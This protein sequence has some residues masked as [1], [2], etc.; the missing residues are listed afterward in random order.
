MNGTR[1]IYIKK[2]V[3]DYRSCVNEASKAV[4]SYQSK[5]IIKRKV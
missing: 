5:M 1:L 4:F 2:I 3:R